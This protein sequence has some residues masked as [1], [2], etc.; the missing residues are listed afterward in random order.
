[1]HLR[2]Q[3]LTDGRR[4]YRLEGDDIIGKRDKAHLRNQLSGRPFVA[5]VGEIHH[6]WSDTSDCFVTTFA[7]SPRRGAAPDQVDKQILH[8]LRTFAGNPRI[9]LDCATVA[10]ATQAA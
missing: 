1:M 2:V 7:V 3:Q 8:R 6:R 9:Q 4:H 10:A 5:W